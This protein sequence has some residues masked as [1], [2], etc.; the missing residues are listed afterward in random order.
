M[1]EIER[2]RKTILDNLKNVTAVNVDTSNYQNGGPTKYEG[3]SKYDES[4]SKQA[5]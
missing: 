4:E 1:E 2:I 3:Y 5:K